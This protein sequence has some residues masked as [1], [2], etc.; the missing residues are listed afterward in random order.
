MKRVPEVVGVVNMG[1][2]PYR[3]GGEVEF[4]V[5]TRSPLLAA[6]QLKG[7]SWMLPCNRTSSTIVATL[8]ATF[9]NKGKGVRQVQ[10]KEEESASP[11]V[12]V[13]AN[14]RIFDANTRERLQELGTCTTPRIAHLYPDGSLQVRWDQP[15]EPQ[16]EMEV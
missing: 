16:L 15:T 3:N 13:V 5:P 12:V 4:R 10:L 1:V 11:Y 8:V 9:D 6:M 14:F 2:Y 7:I